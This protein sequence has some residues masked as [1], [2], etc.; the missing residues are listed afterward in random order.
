MATITP[1]DRREARNFDHSH[2]SP[3]TGVSHTLIEAPLSAAFTG[4]QKTKQIL[5]R[6]T[7]AP[8]RQE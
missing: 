6:T 2:S 4:P 3:G 5:P 8:G 1:K 7:V